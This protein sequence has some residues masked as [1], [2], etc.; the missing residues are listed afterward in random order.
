MS[1]GEESGSTCFT[2]YDV[3]ASRPVC[4]LSHH[5]LLFCSGSR[6][7]RAGCGSR[8][9]GDHMITVVFP[10]ANSECRWVYIVHASCIILFR[11]HSTSTST[12]TKCGF[13]PLTIREVN[14]ASS[15]LGSVTVIFMISPKSEVDLYC[16]GRWPSLDFGLVWFLVLVLASDLRTCA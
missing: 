2:P 8:V 11:L 3:S 15:R 4:F 12:S 10:R 13:G 6:P 5:M 1:P 7:I 16:N 14:P 9:R